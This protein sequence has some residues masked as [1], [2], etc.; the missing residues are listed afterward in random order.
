M[1]HV[2]AKIRTTPAQRSSPNATRNAAK[3]V[4][5]T[6]TTVT[7]FG[8]NGTRPMADINRSAR[9][10]TQASNRVV[11]IDLLSF[12]CLVRGLARFLVHL[13]HLRGDSIPRIAARFLVSVCAHA[14]SELGIPG[15]DDQ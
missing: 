3:N 5:R 10:R 7:W 15:Q 1:S 13:D 6:P 9:R 4:R 8:V 11:N 2:P 14:G 12:C